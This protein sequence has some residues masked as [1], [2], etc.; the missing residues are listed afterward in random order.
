[1][2]EENRYLFYE[3]QVISTQN[4]NFCEL[5]EKDA[6]FPRVEFAD[7]AKNSLNFHEKHTHSLNAY[8]KRTCSEQVKIFVVNHAKKTHVSQGYN[9]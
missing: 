6:R 5:C 3:N 9:L 1:M 4:T 7:F 8:E 2:F